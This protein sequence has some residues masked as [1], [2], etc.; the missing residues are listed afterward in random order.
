MIMQ[1]QEYNKMI[2]KIKKYD[3]MPYKDI[4]EV[5]T[6][7]NKSKKSL[8]P[9]ELYKKYFSKKMHREVFDSIINYLLE[10]TRLRID[11]GDDIIYRSWNPAGMVY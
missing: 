7:L 3:T 1:Q 4:V 11:E 10:T 6:I 9:N 8:T 2:R 5:E